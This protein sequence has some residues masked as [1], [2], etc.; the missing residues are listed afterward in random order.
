M[1]IGTVFG[2]GG[3]GIG[4]LVYG[5]NPLKAGE[6]DRVE[7]AMRKIKLGWF[8]NAMRNRFYFDALYQ[9]TIVNFSIWLADLFDKF[10]YGQPVQEMVDGHLEVVRRPHGIVDGAVH[11]AG[12]VGKYLSI[13]VSWI[14][15][16]IV[17][18]AVNWVGRIGR[19]VSN[20]LDV[21][22]LKIVDGIVNGI[23][24]VIKYLGGWIRPLQSGKVQYYLLL[25]IMLMLALIAAFFMSLYLSI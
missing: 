16:T 5:L 6:M 10:D 8:H 2:L 25:A 21:F 7:A 11:G 14:D 4:Y 19:G 13:G 15:S 20:G 3:L 23:G 9:K 12:I 22:D 17:D 18:G 24:A 1:L